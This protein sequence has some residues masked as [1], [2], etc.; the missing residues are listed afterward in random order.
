MSVTKRVLGQKNVLDA[1][2]YWMVKY[3][4]YRKLK[5]KAKNFL[6]FKSGFDGHVFRNNIFLIAY[7]DLETEN[8]KRK[9]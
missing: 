1:Y 7:L 4:S 8:Q 5:L 6:Y 3:Q 2:F 9:L